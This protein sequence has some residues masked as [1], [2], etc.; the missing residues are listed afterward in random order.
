MNFV[1]RKLKKAQQLFTSIF[2]NSAFFMQGQM[3]IHPESRWFN[4]KFVDKTGG[5]YPLA[6]K[7]KRRIESLEA[8][9]NTRRD[10]I[11]LLLRTIHEREVDGEFAELGVYQGST[12]R[13]IHHYMP[14]RKLHL[15]DT[16][17]G[18][19]E[20][21]MLIDKEKANNLISKKLFTDTSIE[22]V[23][24]RIAPQNDNISFHMGYFPDSIPKDFD[25]KKFAF[26]HLDADLYEP[27]LTGLEYFYSRMS[28]GGYILIHDYNSWIGARLAV[29]EFF[30][31]RKSK[32]IPMPDKSGSALIQIQ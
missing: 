10:M 32:P 17:K 21:S 13:L 30:A 28:A 16:F 8:W 2:Q 7:Q 9:D 23:T 3:D 26:V 15:F 6:N 12:A 18:F 27:T 4:Q 20:K 25:T 5:F 31:S 11:T 29:D 22:H 19:P 14:E 1:T 24:N